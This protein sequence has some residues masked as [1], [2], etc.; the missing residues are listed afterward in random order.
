MIKNDVYCTNRI[1]L[2]KKIQILLMDKDS[3]NVFVNGKNVNTFKDIILN[4]HKT[5]CIERELISDCN[6]ISQFNDYMSE[7]FQFS[8]TE[9]MTQVNLIIANTKQMLSNMKDKDIIIDTSKL[10]NIFD[11][12]CKYFENEVVGVDAHGSRKS[13]DVYLCEDDFDIEEFKSMINNPTKY[14]VMEKLLN[15]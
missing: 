4:I 13:F 10:Y 2:E 9:N 8:K 7:L 5:L 11:E 14:E 6:L 3:I 15:I 12:I 1:Q